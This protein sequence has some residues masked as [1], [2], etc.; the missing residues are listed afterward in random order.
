MSQPSPDRS[1]ESEEE[2]KRRRE[3]EVNEEFDRQQGCGGWEA[4]ADD[5]AGWDS[6]GD[7]DGE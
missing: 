4:Y 1:P 3:Q 5:F 7:G 6:G 2:A